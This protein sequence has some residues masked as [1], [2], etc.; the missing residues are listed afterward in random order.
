MV[1][2]RRRLK[3]SP[4]YHTLKDSGSKF[5]FCNF[6]AAQFPKGYWESFNLLEILSHYSCHLAKEKSVRI[7]FGEKTSWQ[8]TLGL[9]VYFNFAHLTFSPI[10]GHP[11]FYCHPQLTITAFYLML[12]MRHTQPRQLLAF[13]KTSR[14][15]YL[16][17]PLQGLHNASWGLCDASMTPNRGLVKSQ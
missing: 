14:P 1:H 7:V 15:Q 12:L 3:T 17:R 4:P 2:V 13:C 11:G 8:P 6:Y 9:N 10:F 16:V 5:C